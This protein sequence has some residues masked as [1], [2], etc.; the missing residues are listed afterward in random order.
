MANRIPQDFL[1][2]LLSR[3]DIV[4]VIDA[5]VPLRKT[6]RD[7]S[8][9]CPFHAEKTPSFTVSPTKQFYHCFGCGA[10]GSAIG[11]LMAYERLE[12]TDAVE[13][14][15]RLVGLE[16]PRG[17]A[18]AQD[19]QNDLLALIEQAAHFFRRQLREHAT[20]QKAIDYLRN[21]G[22]NGEIIHT[23]GIGYAPPSWD[24]LCKTLLPM[25]KIPKDLITVGLAIERD[26]GEIYDRF[27]ERIIFPIR[28]RRGHTIAFG[29]RA[30]GEMTPKYLNSPETPLF[31]K[32]Q[33]L[34]GLYEARMSE[35][36]LQR[37]LVVEGY[38]DVV[39]LAQHGIRYAVATM[40]TATT[41]EHL[42]RAFRMTNNLFFC[43]DGDR[44]GREAAWRALENVLPLLRDGRQANFLFLPEGED[45][46][47][48]IRKEGQQAFEQRMAKALPLSDYFFE[49]LS[50]AVDIHSIDG[51]ARLAEQARLLLSQLPDSVYRDLMLQR[52]AD[53][54]RL[55]K[56]HIEK[57]L[58]VSPTKPTDRSS[59]NPTRTPIR[60]AIAL[61]LNR[62][63]LAQ[64]VTDINRFKELPVPGLELLLELVKILQSH[65]HINTAALILTRYQGTQ[66]EG[67]LTRLAQWKP[68]YAEKSYE[69]HTEDPYEKEFLGILEHLQK[70]YSPHQMLLESAILKGKLDQLSAEERQ[71][72]KNISRTK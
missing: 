2:Q 15:A 31:H 6:G 25:G 19:G 36:H 38:M 40:G 45:P 9:C 12:F 62:P 68:E 16:L 72:L 39:A 35:R 17:V 66:M 60:L 55:D 27:R 20:R 44:A 43:F 51:R 46:D 33:E 13:E 65:P 23:F 24:N 64:K 63:D 53:L 48:L 57:R 69:K 61:L 26:S 56:K 52:L 58:T 1:E 42:E 14:L 11:F 50:A 8:A 54:A 49:H 59:I 10:H 29:G 67:V 21:R 37:L 70:R 7:Y 22:L 41:P 5:R 71:L 30:L 4:E 32:G 18:A 3:V 47:S 34:Y 28:D